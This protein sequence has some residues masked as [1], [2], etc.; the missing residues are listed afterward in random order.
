MKTTHIETAKQA[1]AEQKQQVE[2][3]HG[4]SVVPMF[5]PVTQDGEVTE[6]AIAWLKPMN[7]QVLGQFLV[8]D[9]TN[10]L[11]AQEIVLR[12]LVIPDHSDKRILDDNNHF[13]IF[14][15]ALQTL[16][17]SKVM[18]AYAGFVGN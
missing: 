5:V 9:R 15:N 17:S 13:D 10:P 4:K 1:A 16:M 18:A 14:V 3:L 12:G 11:A 8:M 6:F 2:T 7:K